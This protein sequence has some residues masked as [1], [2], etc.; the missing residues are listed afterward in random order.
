M[1]KR[2]P[3][4]TLKGSSGESSS[5]S[6]DI[7]MRGPVARQSSKHSLPPAA[8]IG[9]LRCCRRTGWRTALLRGLNFLRRLAA[10][11]RL[12]TSSPAGRGW[13][14]CFPRP[15]AIWCGPPSRIFF[16]SAPRAGRPRIHRRA[17]AG[18]GRSPRDAF[19]TA[20][21][22]A[23]AAG[24]RSPTTRAGPPSIPPTASA[25]SVRKR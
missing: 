11:G 14:S 6:A 7:W 2:W 9:R 13:E 24:S 8:N 17:S 3:Q 19:A 25:W 15:S 1:R 20:S 18:L 4:I 12:S 23:T 16:S 10:Q 5:R 21:P 22:A